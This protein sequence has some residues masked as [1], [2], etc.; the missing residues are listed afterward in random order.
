MEVSLE[1]G[2]IEENGNNVFKTKGVCYV[3]IRLR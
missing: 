2:K 3:A 1:E